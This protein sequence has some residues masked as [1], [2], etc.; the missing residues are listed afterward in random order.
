[1]VEQV[2]MLEFAREDLRARAAA[3]EQEYQ[4]NLQKVRRIA[5]NDVLFRSSLDVIVVCSC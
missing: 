1:M 2:Q 3:Q 4:Q 5:P